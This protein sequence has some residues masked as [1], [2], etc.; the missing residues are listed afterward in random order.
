MILSKPAYCTL[1]VKLERT[2]KILIALKLIGSLK[3]STLKLVP[4]SS[5]GRYFFNY[6]T[7]K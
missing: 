6:T 7:G 5:C 1:K 4:S 2:A 3:I